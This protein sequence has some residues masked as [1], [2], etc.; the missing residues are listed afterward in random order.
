MAQRPDKRDYLALMAL[1]S[2]LEIEFMDG[3]NASLTHP[4][5][6]PAV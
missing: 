3:V 1:V 5:A 4:K 2:N 6:F